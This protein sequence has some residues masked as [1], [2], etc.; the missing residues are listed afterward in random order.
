MAKDRTN[1]PTLENL[2]TLAIAG[3]RPVR[4]KPLPLEFPG[5]HYG[6]PTIPRRVSCA[7]CDPR[8][9]SIA[10]R[11]LSLRRRARTGNYRAHLLV[12]FGGGSRC[13]FR[14]DTNVG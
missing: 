9:R 1:L 12:G 8:D 5:V 7:S 11:A 2:E 4:T 10:R 6:H 14:R 13:E 3:G